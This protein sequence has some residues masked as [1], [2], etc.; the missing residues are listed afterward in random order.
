MS[1]TQTKYRTAADEP[2]EVCM[3]RAEAAML[4]AA[5][6]RSA[7]TWR[8]FADGATGRRVIQ[9][10]VDN[11]LELMLLARKIVMEM[12]GDPD[13]VGLSIED[14]ERGGADGRM[15]DTSP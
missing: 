4:V 9:I 7:Q 6:R 14:I 10:A 1:E 5:L 12:G 2:V 8:D 13:K 15:D 11:A 3:S